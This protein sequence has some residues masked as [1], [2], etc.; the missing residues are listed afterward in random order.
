MTLS[1]YPTSGPN[2]ARLWI[3]AA[4]FACLLAACN[5]AEPDGQVIAIANGEEITLGEL[6][7]EARARGLPIVSNGPLRDSVI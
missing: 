4:A 1:P 3:A 7:E 2:R 5:K 6:N